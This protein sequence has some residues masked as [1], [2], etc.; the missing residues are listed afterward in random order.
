LIGNS[1]KYLGLLIASPLKGL[2]PGIATQLVATK[3]VIHNLYDNLE[4]EETRK[5]VYETVDF[6]REITFAINDL[7][8]ASILADSTLEDVRKL[9]SKYVND[10]SKYRYNFSEY[11]E[12]IKKINKIENAVLNNKIKLDIMSEKM[13]INRKSNE[14]K[15]EK[16]K[17]LNYSNNN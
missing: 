4:W 10:F 2:I 12:I 3:N 15:L 8:H 1:F 11:N 9:K 17:K 6:S 5:V 7:N 13:K 16:V 14:D